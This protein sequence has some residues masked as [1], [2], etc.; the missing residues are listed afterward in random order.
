MRAFELAPSM[1]FTLEQLSQSLGLPLV[2]D[3]NRSVD[4]ACSLE[5]PRAGAL[6]FC[7]K[8]QTLKLLPDQLGILIT[9]SAPAGWHAL[10]SAQPRVSFAQALRLLYPEPALPGGIHPRADVDPS[11][12]IDS[13]AWI[14]PL[15]SVGPGARVGAGSRLLAQVRLGADCQVGQG[16]LLQPGVSLAD[17]CVIGSECVLE[18]GVRLLKG[19][20]LGDRVWLGARNVLRGC[21]VAD[22]V[23]TDNLVNVA[24]GCRVGQH[25]LLIAQSCLG[26]DTVMQPYSLV[27]AQGVVV[28]GVELAAQV[29]VAGRGVVYES[30][31]TPG[32]A[33]AGDPAVA[34]AVEMKNR[35][36]RARALAAYRRGIGGET[37]N[38]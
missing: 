34:Y 3:P 18:P 29:Q 7:E 24:P 9:P 35:A 16:C 19:T 14:G 23:K 27:A 22:G 20:R 1:S 26:P 6:S 21:S 2:G 33:V 32:A 12:H 15:C 13:D 17:G 38:H 36:L 28:G 11:A 8:P 10:I 4:G 5:H 31:L 25:A 30:V 37:G